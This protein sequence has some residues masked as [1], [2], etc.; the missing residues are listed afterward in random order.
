MNQHDTTLSH[1][2][3]MARQLELNPDYR[4]LRK[5]DART[6]FNTRDVPDDAGIAIVLDT[7]TTGREEGDRIIELGLVSFAYHRDTGEVYGALDTYNA[8]ED[9]GMPI[10]PE[11]SKVNGITDEM[12]AGKRLDDE[13]IQ[14]MVEMADFVIAHNAGFDRPYCERRLPFFKGKPWAC[15]LTQMDWA[16]AGISSAKLEF[17]AFRLGFFYDAHRAENDCLA[18]LH[19]MNQPLDDMEGHTALRFIL[20]EY[21]KESRRLWATGSPFEAKDLLKA[22]GYRWSDGSK[23]STEK[24]WHTDVSAEL[25]EDELAWLKSDVFLR[26]QFSVPVDRIDAFNRF[27]DR[28]GQTERLYR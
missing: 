9:P 19:A 25:L 12:V 6:L 10:P 16:A 18:L 23:A 28:R 8:L 11:A 3:Q 5:F 15:S 24:A 26:R 17:I 21:Q 2:E 13:K 20:A 14:A 1:D 7:E 22:R 27:T 4:V